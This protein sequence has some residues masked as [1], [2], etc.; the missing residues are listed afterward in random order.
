VK[1]TYDVWKNHPALDS[2]L[3]TAMEHMGEAEIEDAFYKPLEFGTGG[4]RGKMGPGTNRMNVHTLKK[5][6]YGFAKYVIE[7]EPDAKRRGIVIAYDNREHSDT[8][9]WAAASVI[10]ACGM[11]AFVFEHMRPT[12]LL[13]FAVRHQGAAGGIVI[14]ASHN[15]PEYNGFKI[16]D[17]DGCQLVPRLAD[18]VVENVEAIEDVFAVPSMD[19]DEAR[20]NGLIAVLG[21]DIDDAYLNEVATVPMRPEAKKTITIVFTPLHG[22]CR[23]IGLRALTEA[24]YDVV[25]VEEQMVPDSR[26]STVKSPNPEDASA[27]EYAIKYGRQHKAD[28]LI[29]TDPDGDRL[30]LGVL[31]QGEYVFLTGNQ[32]GAIFI[33]SILDHHKR[34]GTMPEHGIVYNTIVTSDFG[35]AIAHTYGVEVQSTLTGFKFIGER[36]KAIESTQKSF[37]M[38][39]EESYG[40]IVK[41]FVRDKD[42]VQAMVFAS[43]IANRLKTKG[44]TLVDYLHDLY[45][46]YGTYRE[47]NINLTLDGKAGEAKIKA[48]MSHFRDLMPKSIAKRAVIT[49]ED[50]LKS[51]RYEGGNEHII[52]LPKSNVIKFSLEGDAWFVLRPSGTEPKLKIYIAVKAA[53]I[54]EADTTLRTLEEAIMEIVHDAPEADHHKDVKQ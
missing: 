11:R 39:Y 34:L 5:A 20:E 43:D 6:A 48:I 14:T 42:A 28:V 24:G 31:H 51:L 53:S 1:K 46:K 33:E 47:K 36:M 49:I 29:A 26:F 44:K 18:Q 45:E 37:L 22:A 9:A 21:R 4:M 32:T 40:Y 30:G 16:Y 27:F 19:T 15:P 23:E 10:A 52:D 8:F 38:G 13:S 54:T 50:Y 2:D 3:K 12:P 7:H 25:T 41:D 35:A 17:A